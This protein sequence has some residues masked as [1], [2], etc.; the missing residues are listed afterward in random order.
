MPSGGTVHG[1]GGTQLSDGARQ[2]RLGPAHRCRFVL[3]VG[4]LGGEL[5]VELFRHERE[6]ALTQRL[7]KAEGVHGWG[8]S[9]VSCRQQKGGEQR[10][11]TMTDHAQPAGFDALLRSQVAEGRRS[12][13][14]VG[15]DADGVGVDA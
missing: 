9:G 5:S 12:F 6:V 11:L 8:R 3:A 4:S 2:R 7:E 13:L 1:A 15:C 14:L 10:P